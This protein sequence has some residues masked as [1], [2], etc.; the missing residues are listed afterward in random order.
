MDES[1]VIIIYT[2]DPTAYHV[3]SINSRHTI[4]EKK[5]LDKK[6][7]FFSLESCLLVLIKDG[8]LDPLRPQI[9]KRGH[10]EREGHFHL[11]MLKSSQNSCIDA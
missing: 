1:I 8:Q 7:L 10:A 4:V 6:K 5:N 11:P 2:H 3:A 9:V